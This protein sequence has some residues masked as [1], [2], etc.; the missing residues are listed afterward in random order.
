M[1]DLIQVMAGK[2]IF[3]KTIW[4]EARGEE[5][6]GQILVARVI[7]ERAAQNRP[8]WGGSR[9]EDV[10]RQPNQF[11]CWNNV[12]DIDVTR[13]MAAYEAIRAWSDE[14]YDEPL[15]QDPGCPDHYNNPKREGY[16]NERFNVRMLFKVGRHMFYRSN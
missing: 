8:E 13:E 4:A 2:V 3:A 5:L 9:I 1:P 10:C 16:L 12:S 7:R 6:K 14:M 15:K 11:E